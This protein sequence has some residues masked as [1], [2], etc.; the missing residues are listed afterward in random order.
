[1]GLCLQITS[2]KFNIVTPLISSPIVHE[3]G[4][5]LLVFAIDFFR[6]RCYQSDALIQAFKVETCPVPVQKSFDLKFFKYMATPTLFLFSIMSDK[7][8][9]WQTSPTKIF[10]DKKG[11]SSWKRSFILAWSFYDR[12]Q[13]RGC[14]L[15]LKSEW[16]TS[17]INIWARNLEGKQALIYRQLSRYKLLG[18]IVPVS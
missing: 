4:L 6:K 14:Y 7:N 9:L 1:M 11:P 12:A 13:F 5:I 16:S 17:R 15:G 8:V 2:I 3:T 18:G 10:S